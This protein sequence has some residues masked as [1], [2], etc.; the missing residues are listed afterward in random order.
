MTVVRVL[1][2]MSVND[3]NASRRMNG[4]VELFLN[5]HGLKESPREK[6]LGKAIALFSLLII[7]IFAF[8]MG[9][10]VALKHGTM[11][12]PQYWIDALLSL[13][14]FAILVLFI[15]WVTVRS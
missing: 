11:S 4:R 3:E 5:K 6:R 1:N 9:A 14:L 8:G 2:R 15:S 10:V 13:I 12:T 7:F